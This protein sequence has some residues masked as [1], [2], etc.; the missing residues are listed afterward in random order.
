MVDY[1]PK[2]KMIVSLI[3][4]QSM[5]WT[6]T[7]GFEPTEENQWVKPNQSHLAYYKINELKP[8]KVIEKC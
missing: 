3:G 1:Q 4:W 2:K 7:V 6:E 5:T 8:I